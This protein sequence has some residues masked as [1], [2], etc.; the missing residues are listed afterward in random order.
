MKIATGYFGNLRVYRNAKLKPLA[1]CQYAPQ[2]FDGAVESKLAP[3]K[4]LLQQIKAGAI[5]Y[6]TEFVPLYRMHLNRLGINEVK[7][8]LSAHGDNL[9][10]LCYEKDHNECHRKVLAEFLREHGVQV[11]EHGHISPIKAI[12]TQGLLF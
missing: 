6:D 8:L 7:N 4:S 2:W 10:L 3:P 1:I 5:D 9:V 12:A 11:Q